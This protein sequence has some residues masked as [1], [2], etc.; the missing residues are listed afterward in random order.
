MVT[1]LLDLSIGCLLCRNLD[2]ELVSLREAALSICLASPRLISTVG[3]RAREQQQRI[4]HSV[5]GPQFHGL[6]SEIYPAKVLSLNMGYQ[7]LAS[8][9]RPS[10][11]PSNNL[12]RCPSLAQTGD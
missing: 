7:N 11:S 6:Y 9:C 4:R 1:V 5:Q 8:T 2:P 12:P 3:E 10:P